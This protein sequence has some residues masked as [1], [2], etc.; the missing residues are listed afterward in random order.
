MTQDQDVWT[1]EV[2]RCEASAR[3]EL[4]QTFSANV[5]SSEQPEEAFERLT[6]NA[7]Q[8]LAE[9]RHARRRLNEVSVT[10]AED[11]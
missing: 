5:Y 11:L 1:R 6:A 8:R 4:N 10:H 7:Q 3:A 9:L 2:T